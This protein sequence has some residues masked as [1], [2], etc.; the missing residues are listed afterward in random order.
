M[1]INIMN[2]ADTNFLVEYRDKYSPDNYLK[3]LAQQRRQMTATLKEEKNTLSLEKILTTKGINAR[4]L[5][6]HAN[7]LEDKIQDAE[8]TPIDKIRICDYFCRRLYGVLRRISAD[9]TTIEVL[10]PLILKGIHISKIMRLS[11]LKWKNERVVYDITKYQYDNDIQTEHG[12]D[13]ID[14]LQILRVLAR[15]NKCSSYLKLEILGIL[16]DRF[17]NCTNLL[18]KNNIADVVLHIDRKIGNEMLEQLRRL[19]VTR[20]DT[21]NIKTIYNDSQNV[22]DYDINKSENDVAQELVT[23]RKMSKTSFNFKKVEEILFDKFPE[24]TRIVENVLERIQIDVAIFNCGHTLAEIFEAV[25]IY[26]ID[27]KN[28]EWQASMFDRIKEE[29]CATEGYCST[30][31]M[32]RMINVIQGF[33][34]NNDKLNLKISD[35]KRMIAILSHRLN[36]KIM[37]DEK[38]MDVL[39]EGNND[40]FAEIVKNRVMDIVNVLRKED[41][42]VKMTIV[43]DVVSKYA[44][45]SAWEL[46]NNQ[47]V[48]KK[49]QT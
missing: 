23:L 20:N 40:D 3:N 4:T 7:F 27:C 10:Q 45:N 15:L 29:F 44:P 8:T 5:T 1:R 26:T 47:I 36:N 37:D 17:A 33:T 18:L 32:G 41:E 42:L 2:I 35:N 14:Y 24:H 38:A 11:F 34:G 39:M 31:Y 30:G 22:H 9:D 48:Y 28:D 21:G 25:W 49:D 6:L 16:V 19:E 46:K 43:L 13:E 12:L